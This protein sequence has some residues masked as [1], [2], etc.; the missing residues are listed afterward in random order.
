MRGLEARYLM[1]RSR[2]GLIAGVDPDEANAES[3]EACDLAQAQGAWD[4]RDGIDEPPAMFAGEE[5][6][7]HWWNL[8]ASFYK[9]LRAMDA[10]PICREPLRDH[11]P[12]HD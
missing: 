1:A 6:L 9:K 3:L 11:C 12:D 10:C 8:G 7:L 2:I 5:V 4:A